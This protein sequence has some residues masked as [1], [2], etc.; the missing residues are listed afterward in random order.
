MEDQFYKQIRDQ[1]PNLRRYGRAMTGNQEVADCAVIMLMQQ[2]AGHKDATFD[3]S[4]LRISL[5]Q[6]L[7]KQIGDDPEGRI[8]TPASRCILFLTQ[9][10][11]F[12]LEEAG[13]IVG[14]KASEARDLQEQAQ[15]E[16]K[17]T[18]K[19]DVLIIEDEAFISM[20]LESIV[21]SL[22]HRVINVA[23]T[24][25]EAVKA[26]EDERPTLILSDIHLADDSSGIDAVDDIQKFCRAPAVFVTAYPD[27]LLTGTKPEPIFLINKPFRD[28]ELM[29]TVSQ[30]NYLA[31]MTKH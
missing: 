12:S 1:L 21:E 28:N 2:Y 27:R 20:H 19:A 14:V 31:H 25:Q 22:D 5:Y 4:E 18:D 24:R 23:T 16:I 11:N 6:N 7:R 3:P 9:V 26:A 30:A 13:Q 8:F 10:E 17:K 15:E 29:A